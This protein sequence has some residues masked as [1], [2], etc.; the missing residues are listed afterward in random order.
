MENKSKNKKFYI[1]IEGLEGGFNLFPLKKWIRD[2]HKLI[3]DY[4]YNVEDI[5]HRIEDKLIKLGWYNYFDEVNNIQILSKSKENSFSAGF[6]KNK[7]NNKELKVKKIKSELKLGKIIFKNGKLNK[8]EFISHQLNLNDS[9][10]LFWLEKY[11]DFLIKEIQNLL[12]G[13]DLFEQ[14]GK[15]NKFIKE[16]IDAD[17]YGCYIFSNPINEEVLYIGM[18]GKLKTDGIYT[19]HSIV[20]RL[21]ATRLKDTV[22]KKD[23]STEN[24][25]KGLFEAFNI[26]KLRVTVLYSKPDFPSGYLEALLLFDFFKKYKV[27]PILN[28]AF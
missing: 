12:L 17:K 3:Q 21:Q 1:E 25:L 6:I 28:N 11:N 22:T 24:Y 14:K 15:Y 19:N 9:F 7:N 13:L 26:D 16:N 27:L 4:D 18:A 20:N 2:N 10:N 23:V 5:T 8:D